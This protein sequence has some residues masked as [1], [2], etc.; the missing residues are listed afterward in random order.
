MSPFYFMANYR[1]IWE[2]HYGPIPKDENGVT[3]DIHHIDGN[4]KNNCI[5]NLKAVSLLEHWQIHIDQSDYAAAN[6]ISDRMQGLVEYHDMHGENNP[7]YKRFWINNGTNNRFIKDIK[8]M[9]I[10]WNIGMSNTTRQKVRDNMKGTKD[11][12]WIN[13]GITNKCIEKNS[14][15]P[16]GWLKGM[17]KKY[18]IG[19]SCNYG[20][21]LISKDSECKYIEKDKTLPDGW[22]IGRYKEYCKK[23]GRRKN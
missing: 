7:A 6:R 21:V 10:G 19:T 13:D 3:Y 14:D 23:Y 1:K 11:T 5:S 16:D 4:R 17:I 20:R 9:P 12:I 15:I 2:D 22:K 8:D 18:K